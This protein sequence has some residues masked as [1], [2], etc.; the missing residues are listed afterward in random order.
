MAV[1]SIDG[2]ISEYSTVV[3]HQNG[4]MN[5]SKPVGNFDQ[6]TLCITDMIDSWERDLITKMGYINHAHTHT[7]DTRW[8]SWVRVRVPV[9]QVC[10]ALQIYIYVHLLFYNGDINAEEDAP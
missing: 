4:S 3:S 9:P 8:Y 7:R 10:Q 1:T 2:L 5:I 6:K